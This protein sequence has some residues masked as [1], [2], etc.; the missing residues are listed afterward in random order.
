[1]REQR[2]RAGGYIERELGS[3]MLDLE[4]LFELQCYGKI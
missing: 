2:E 4:S 1:M 3:G